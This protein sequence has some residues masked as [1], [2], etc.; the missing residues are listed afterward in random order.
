MSDPMTRCVQ[1]VI[2][3]VS[4]YKKKYLWGKIKVILMIVL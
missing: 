1:L 3:E 4:C 2:L